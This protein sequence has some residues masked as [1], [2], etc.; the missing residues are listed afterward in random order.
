M[1]Q[2]LS[3]VAL[4]AVLG[5]LVIAQQQPPTSPPQNPPASQAQVGEVRTRLS[6][7]TGVNYLVA[8]RKPG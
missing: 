2:P 7:D 3:I 1:K 8:C 4:S 5:A 6:D